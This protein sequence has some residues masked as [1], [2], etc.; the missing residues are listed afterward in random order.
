[1]LTS[2]CGMSNNASGYQITPGLREV[3]KIHRA[4]AC[5][6]STF[7]PCGSQ[8]RRVLSKTVPLIGCNVTRLD[9]KIY[10]D[11]NKNS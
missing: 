6:G 3:G 1:M 2:N 11:N 9:S 5:L 8:I 7:T 4:R 10:K